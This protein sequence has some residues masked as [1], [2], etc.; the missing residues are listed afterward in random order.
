[1]TPVLILDRA[2]HLKGYIYPR[3]EYW[4]GQ[5]ADKAI[6]CMDTGQGRGLIR[7]YPLDGYWTGQGTDKAI[8][9]D[10]HWTGQTSE[11]T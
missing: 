8:P 1:M 10:R 4:T 3:Y 9:L 11:N 7:L 5:R 6:L 2:E